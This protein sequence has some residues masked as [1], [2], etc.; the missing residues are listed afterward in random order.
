MSNDT[1]TI[2]AQPR[3]HTGTRFSRRLRESGRLPAVIY[4]HKTDPV[5]ISVDEKEVLTHLRHGSHVINV[6]VEGGQRFGHMSPAER[7]QL[8][9][10]MGLPKV[11]F[12]GISVPASR[13]YYIEHV[14]RAEGRAPSVIGVPY[15]D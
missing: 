4:G 3:E 13:D 1:P 9:R 15:W 5:S 7:E 6:E 2:T 12:Q 8:A 11:H 14:D 10:L